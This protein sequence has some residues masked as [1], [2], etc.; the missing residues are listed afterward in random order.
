MASLNVDSL[1]TNISVHKIVDT[2]IDNLY[3]GNENPP[4]IPKHDLRNAFNIATK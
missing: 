3:H 1:V 4:S 2:C